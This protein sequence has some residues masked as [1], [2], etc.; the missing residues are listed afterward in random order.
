MNNPIRFISV[1]STLLGGLRAPTVIAWGSFITL[2]GVIDRNFVSIMELKFQI[3]LD[4][5]PFGVRHCAQ[6]VV[7]RDL[8]AAGG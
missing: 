2:T 7:H 1:I 5:E 3:G 8:R 4:V 6:A